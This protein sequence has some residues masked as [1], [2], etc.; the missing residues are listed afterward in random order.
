MEKRPQE[1]VEQ[2]RRAIAQTPDSADQK[3]LFEKLAILEVE[4]AEL[5]RRQQAV[6]DAD[7]QLALAN[8]SM[9]RWRVAIGILLA[10][11]VGLG[12]WLVAS[13]WRAI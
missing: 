3:A 12:L 11:L 9:L 6:R 13:V 1:L 7:R 8:K 5:G 10:A 4:L 2:L